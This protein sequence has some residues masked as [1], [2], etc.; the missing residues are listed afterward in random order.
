MNEWTL[1]FCWI[2]V[3]FQIPTHFP[4]FLH[5]YFTFNLAKSKCNFRSVDELV[6]SYLNSCFVFSNVPQCY[7]YI[8]NAQFMN[9]FTALWKIIIHVLDIDVSFRRYTLKDKTNSSLLLSVFL[10]SSIF[11]LKMGIGIERVCSTREYFV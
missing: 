11:N 2:I 10:K 1:D 4:Y 5:L 8:W 9:S 6:H 3:H 7:F